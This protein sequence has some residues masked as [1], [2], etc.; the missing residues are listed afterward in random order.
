MSGITSKFPLAKKL[1]YNFRQANFLKLYHDINNVDWSFLESQ[2]DVNIALEGFYSCLYK[3]FDT[4][5]PR[6]TS[7]SSKFPPWITSEIKQ[8]IKTKD[9]YRRK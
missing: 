2:E 7:S 8:N 3:L 6:I 1:R 4:S 5:V 9:Y